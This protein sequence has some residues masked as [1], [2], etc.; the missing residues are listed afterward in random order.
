MTT[1]AAPLTGA[2]LKLQGLSRAS[3]S[4]KELLCA[5]KMFAHA[6]A[7]KRGSVTID[8]VQAELVA[9]GFS[10]EDLGCAAGALFIS[11]EWECVGFKK[12]TRTSNR[13]RRILVWKL[14]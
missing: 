3:L 4:R 1:S 2:Q 6:I 11:K 14:R 5:A 9:N 7:Q 8:D 13:A 10:S 12:S